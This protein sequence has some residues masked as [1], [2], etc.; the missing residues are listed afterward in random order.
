[1]RAERAI[2]SCFLA[3]LFWPQTGDA[4]FNLKSFND[5]RS[6]ATE[7]SSGRSFCAFV[8]EDDTE[9]AEQV[10]WLDEVQQPP[11]ELPADVP[12]LAP[13]LKTHDGKP[14]ETAE[15]WQIRRGEIREW[16]IDFLQPLKR[17]DQP[18]K[19]TVLNE[20]RIGDVVRMRISY[21]S[22][23]DWPTEAYL[24]K[25]AKL[26]G[27]VPGVVVLHSTVDHSIHQPAGVKGIREK[28]FGLELAQRG[29]V[30][31]CPRNFLWPNNDEIKANEQTAQFLKRYPD[32]KGMAKMLLDAQLAVDILAS[33]PEVDAARLGSIG[34]SLGA[35]EVV[36]LAAL[37]ERIKVTVSSEGGI[38]TGYS[39]WD[40]LWYLG[41]TIKQ[42]DFGH[43][44][45]ELLALIAPRP[46]LLLGGDSA[47]GD[48]SWPFI[49][50]SLPVYRLYSDRPPLGLFNHKQ[51]HSV[52]PEAEKR[53]YD[54]FEAYLP[55]FPH[56]S[57]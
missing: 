53:I 37:D 42:P 32:S 45:H 3:I 25:P 43:D 10:A 54:W 22:G 51:G 12:K 24:L 31:I 35:K 47:D 38:G 33:L 52:P 4:G 27:K 30:T 44:H 26:T 23:K 2:I 18:P 6:A 41:P 7:Y 34:H 39:N 28:F 29:Y 15:H 20:E 19:F 36:Y 17:D 13:L 49:Q 1:M 5:A 11:K 21:E 56:E 50:E 9:Q 8:A 40:A 16:W 46:F 48:R 55:V 57:N 14:I